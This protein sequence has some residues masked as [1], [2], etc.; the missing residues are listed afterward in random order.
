MYQGYCR[1]RATLA[2][3]LEKN[4]PDS[5]KP[6][7]TGLWRFRLSDFRRRCEGLRC[8]RRARCRFMVH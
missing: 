7:N 3:L 5:E 6:R 2:K 1:A 4:A 8:W